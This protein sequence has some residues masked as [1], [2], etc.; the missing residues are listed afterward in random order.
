LHT[1]DGSTGEESEDGAAN[2]YP[3]LCTLLTAAL[4]RR[5]KPKA[6]TGGEDGRRITE[7]GACDV[8]KPRPSGRKR[9][10]KTNS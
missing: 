1:V 6:K 10:K 7:K 3:A 9:E 4:G 8:K 2:Y 5:A